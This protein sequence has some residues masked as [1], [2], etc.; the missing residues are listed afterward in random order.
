M[1]ATSRRWLMPSSSFARRASLP[2]SSDT[3]RRSC[4]CTNQD[5]ACHLARGAH[6]ADLGAVAPLAQ[7]RVRQ[8][9]HPPRDEEALSERG[10]A[11]VEDELLP[12]DAL[13]DARHIQKLLA[14]KGTMPHGGHLGAQEWHPR[15]GRLRHA[16]PERGP[17]DRD[18]PPHRRRPA[19]GSGPGDEW[20][21]APLRRRDWY[22]DCHLR[23]PPMR[24]GLEGVDSGLTARNPL[25]H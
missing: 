17:D 2:A 9:T 6:V 7:H 1:R 8:R 14:A 11:D 25:Q 16:G 24:R 19:R 4:P 5:R 20:S 23:L 12:S 21:G 13:V 18:L 10:A 22:P 15:E 3:D